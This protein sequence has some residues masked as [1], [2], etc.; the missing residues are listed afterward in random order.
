MKFTEYRGGVKA[1]H[2]VPRDPGDAPPP[3]FPTLLRSFYYISAG[4][5]GGAVMIVE[6]LGTR[7][8]APWV[9]TSHFVWTAQIAVTLAAL[10]CGYYAG[11]RLA[12]RGVGPGALYGCLLASAFFLA[13]A[14]LLRSWTMPA[15]L[16]L[17][18]SMGSL[19]ASAELFFI[20]LALMAMTGPYLVRVLALSLRGAGGTAGRLS[21]VSTIGSFAGTAIVGYVL[22]P[23]LPNSVTLLGTAGLLALLAVVYFLL[24]PRR[25]ASITAV[26]IV[27][28]AGAAAGAAGLG[29]E[30]LHSR[31]L[32]ELYRGSSAFGVLQ[33]VQPVGSHLRYALNDYLIQDAWDAD[34]QESTAMF[35]YMLE[36]LARVYTDR[37]DDVLCIGMGVG[38]VPRE[39]ARDGARTDVVEINPGMVGLAERWFDLDP[40]TFNL[41]IGDGRTYVRETR[42]RYDAVI[43]DA[44]LGDSVP[45]HLL[46]REAFSAIRDVLKP[47][48]V[49]VINTFVDFADPRDWFGASLYKTLS[50]VFPSVVVHGA[51]SANTLFVASPR[52]DLAM[53]HDPVLTGVHPAA[54]ADVR[55]AYERRWTPDPATGIVL[56]D[57]FNP[58]E[59]Y[60]A[61]K[62]ERY[63][64]LLA[65]SVGEG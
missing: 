24:R 61:A 35:T 20:P 14:V 63:R 8:L 11:G 45:T 49:L 39:L 31:G 9:G 22:V 57:D 50:S 58:L 53:L 65:L 26:A 34:R 60:D 21:A 52:A 32:V 56:T 6:I 7:M 28:A 15:L 10:A 27:I 54:I 18:L 2:G 37:L 17:P 42:K 59:Y 62:R 38:I 46:S 25:G 48:G 44:F 4:I 33:V 47:Q 12:D 40:R 55:E 1:G 29:T 36:G 3:V 13:G 51:P 19:L 43:L 64:R 16:G 30:G 41:T 5:A 23:L